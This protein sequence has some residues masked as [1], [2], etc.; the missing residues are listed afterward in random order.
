MNQYLPVKLLFQPIPARGRKP[1]IDVC[2]VVFRFDFNLSPQGDGNAADFFNRF[3]MVLFQLIP[4]RG[5]KL[6]AADLLPACIQFQ[7]IPARGRKRDVLGAVSNTANFNFSP[8]GDGNCNRGC[9]QRR[10]CCISTYPRKGTET[11]QEEHRQVLQ[12]FQ[13]IPVRG[14]KPRS[15]ILGVNLCR[16]QLIPAR[17]RKLQSW[18]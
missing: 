16:F 7:L 11:N 13:L 14:R 12:A 15:L 5:R 10:S 2:N 18:L 9:K 17:R 3:N 6:G 4:A 8:Q 1:S